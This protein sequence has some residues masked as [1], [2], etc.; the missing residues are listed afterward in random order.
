MEARARTVEVTRLLKYSFSRDEIVD[1]A[2]QQADSA[3][4][5]NEL[6]AQLDSIKADFK[7]RLGLLETSIDKAQR[8]IR[9]GYEMREIECEV[10][11]HTPEDG[12][13]RIVRLDTGE[14]VAIEYMLPHERQEILPFA[15]PEPEQEA[16]QEPRIWPKYDPETGFYDKTNA[17]RL[18]KDLG[19]E[20]WFE[21]VL[22]EVDEG[23]W[24]STYEY[25]I[26][27][28]ERVDQPIT[29]VHEADEK[30]TCI[31]SAG[32]MACNELRELLLKKLKGNLRT[33][34]EAAIDAIDAYRMLME[35]TVLAEQKPAS[36][37]ES[38]PES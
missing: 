35:D 3:F 32:I 4:S 17:L 19:E 30:A 15:Q 33:K 12:Q 9:D 23:S 21:I 2:R 31:Y 24:Q 26:E 38:G 25:K 27:R 18:H 20:D 37:P 1:I 13:K 34:I 6:E 22:L 28:F 29:D 14:E 10:Q 5:R 11:F 16:Q 36:G 8:K 7:G